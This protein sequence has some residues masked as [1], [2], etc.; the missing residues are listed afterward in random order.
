MVGGPF[1]ALIQGVHDVVAIRELADFHRTIGAAGEEPSGRV[2]VQ[3]GDTLADVFEETRTR[4]L[5]RKGIEQRMHRQAP[6]FDVTVSSSTDEKLFVGIQGQALDGRFVCL[7]S[8]PLL[9]LANV[10]Y[11][12]VAFLSPADE[13][14]VLRRQYQGTGSLLVTRETLD[15]GLILRKQ[16]IPER[17][18]ASLGAMAGRGY[19][20]ASAEVDEIGRYFSVAGVIEKW[21]R[22]ALPAGHLKQTEVSIGVGDTKLIPML[23]ET[24]SGDFGKGAGWPWRRHCRLVAPF[25]EG[26]RAVLRSGQIEW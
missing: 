17:D 14:L 15:E 9:P 12:D 22:G 2:D 5:S 16:G 7:K 10:E 3:L 6:D 20:A 8:M 4:M 13:Q 25:P 11:I 19:E 21:P 18:V 23:G 24:Y 1:P 26:D